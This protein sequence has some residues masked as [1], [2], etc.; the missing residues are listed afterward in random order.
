MF[1]SFLGLG[2]EQLSYKLDGKIVAS[3]NP[4]TYEKDFKIEIFSQK[5]F[6]F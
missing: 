4:A 5:G 6:S 1:C 3:Y 2:D